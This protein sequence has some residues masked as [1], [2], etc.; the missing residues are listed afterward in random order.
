M[1][2]MIRIPVSNDGKFHK[3]NKKCIICQHKFK[4]SVANW[5][6]ESC[7][8]KGCNHEERGIGECY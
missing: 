4:S 5:Y 2:Y 1:S 3:G 8:K 7:F 6:C